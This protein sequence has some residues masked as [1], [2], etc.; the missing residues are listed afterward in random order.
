MF[1]IET[2][3][4][5]YNNIIIDTSRILIAVIHT[6]C[7]A[8]DI[9]SVF[10]LHTLAICIHLQYLYLESQAGCHSVSNELICYQQSDSLMDDTASHNIIF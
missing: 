2:I 9:M 5:H 1:N 6:T 4:I 10:L 7:I 8:E 3:Y